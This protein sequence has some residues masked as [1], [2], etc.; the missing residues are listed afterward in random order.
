M[1]NLSRFPLPLV[2]LVVGLAT[3][4]LAQ[5]SPAQESPAQEAPLQK[6]AESAPDGD[7]SFGASLTLARPTAVAV[8]SVVAKPELRDR[9]VLVEGTIADVCTRKG[10]WLVVSDGTEQ[11]RVTFKDYGFFV[12][13][14][15]KGRRVLLEGIVSRKELTE[16]EAR[17][18]AEEATSGPKPEEITGTQSVLTMEATGV[19]IL[20]E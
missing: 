16:D 13:K 12:P 3:P 5:D 18:Y 10:C 9:A 7:R 1:K 17:H 15:S 6:P 2:A 4:A 14:D 11:M 8:S 20:A 19:V